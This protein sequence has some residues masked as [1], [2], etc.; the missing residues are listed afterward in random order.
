[1]SEAKVQETAQE[2][3]TQS[4]NTSG[5]DNR[6]SELLREVMQKKERLNSAMERA[7]TLQSKYD[8]LQK[9]IADEKESNKIKEMESKGEYDKIMADMASKLEAS[10]K[11]SVA[12]DEYQSNRRTALLE[13]LP[14]EDRTI[15]DGL[16]L[17]KLEAHVDKFNSKSSPAR[18]DNSKPSET[19]GYGSALDFAVNDPQGY[20]KAKKGTGSISKFGNIF[21][22]LGKD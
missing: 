21:N 2:M 18:V 19:G 12:W 6:D 22:P 5:T 7:E 10:E 17:N 3:T 15:Y 9:Q 14:E 8:V 13:K 1:M 4:Q 11:K 20:E 16:S